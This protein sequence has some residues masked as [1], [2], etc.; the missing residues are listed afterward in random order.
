L[1]EWKRIYEEEESLSI[2]ERKSNQL[3]KL[4]NILSS[5]QTL[6]GPAFIPAIKT[7]RKEKLTEDENSALQSSEGKDEFIARIS[8]LEK[9]FN[10]RFYKALEG[11]LG[12]RIFAEINFKKP[13]KVEEVAIKTDV[14]GEEDTTRTSKLP[15]GFNKWDL[16]MIK[17]HESKPTD[18]KRIWI[19]YWTLKGISNIGE[20]LYNPTK[21]LHYFRPHQISTPSF[22]LTEEHGRKATTQSRNYYF[23]ICPNPPNVE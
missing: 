21:D 11:V 18:G 13:E 5:F 2:E 4:E 23:R 15:K 10:E 22:A 6:F 14:E 1:E 16:K 8:G 9:E 7:A 12:K 17:L 3:T 19:E 20:I